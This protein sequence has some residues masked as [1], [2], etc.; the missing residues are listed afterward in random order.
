MGVIDSIRDSFANAYDNAR[1]HP[2][3]TGASILAGMVG[4]PLA[5]KGSQYLFDRYN[6]ANGN[7]VLD[8][9]AAQYADSVA[10]TANSVNGA[11]YAQS[12][13]Y[14]T[15]GY[16]AGGGYG[17]NAAID[18]ALTGGYSPTARN[19]TPLPGS[20]DM[21]GLVPDYGAEQPMA[22]VGVGSGKLAR[23]KSWDETLND[24]YASNPGSGIN[25]IGGT[26]V[27]TG[28]NPGMGNYNSYGGA[29]QAFAK[30]KRQDG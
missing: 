6:T 26:M 25:Y 20:A 21:L 8:N 15:T 22:G 18:A 12:R 2:I 29:N 1:M 11:D 14:D 10:G 28:V 16:G 24:N 17:S 3:Q 13:G 30:N 23:A 4:G 19:D 7:T 27:I 5:S 9:Q